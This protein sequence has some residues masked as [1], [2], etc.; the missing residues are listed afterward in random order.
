MTDGERQ[1]HKN[2][3]LK[4]ARARTYIWWPCRW[5]LDPWLRWTCSW[6]CGALG[7]Q[8]G[9]QQQQ[10]HSVRLRSVSRRRRRRRRRKES[11]ELRE[12]GSVAEITQECVRACV[13]ARGRAGGRRDG[14]WKVPGCPGYFY[15]SLW[16]FLGT[17]FLHHPD[18]GMMAEAGTP[19]Q[20]AR[21]HSRAASWCPLLEDTYTKGKWSWGSS[22]ELLFLFV[23][24]LRGNEQAFTLKLH[25]FQCV[26][27]LIINV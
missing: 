19:T 16:A 24:F 5:G 21:A 14:C 18:P 9:P 4:R 13:R 20:A 17:E 12:L 8:R 1:R 3:R 22:L 25:N 6:G 2:I 7:G 15:G 26:V 10:H 11:R 23:N 27:I